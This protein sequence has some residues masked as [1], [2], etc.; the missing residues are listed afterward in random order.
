MGTK[1]AK[2]K[3]NHKVLELEG[4][5]SRLWSSSFLSISDR[6]LSYKGMQRYKQCAG[7]PLG[8][9]SSQPLAAV[10]RCLALGLITSSPV[11]Q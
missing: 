3:A 10:M 4:P 2:L 5:S 11:E 9:G 8:P 6:W 1:G 7:F